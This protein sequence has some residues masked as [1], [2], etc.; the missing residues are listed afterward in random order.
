MQTREGF[1]SGPRSQNISVGQ[2]GGGG[3]WYTR[4]GGREGR[5]WYTRRGGGGRGRLAY[6]TRRRRRLAYITNGSGRK[7]EHCHSH[8]IPAKV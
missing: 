7:G 6:K 4:R 5:G 1:I 2:G 8:T 3:G